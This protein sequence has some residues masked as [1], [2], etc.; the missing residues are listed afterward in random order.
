MTIL[1]LHVYLPF[2]FF[3]CHVYFLPA[4]SLLFTLFIYVPFHFPSYYNSLFIV[5][6]LCASKFA[7]S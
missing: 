2:L 5:V 3:I 7:R 4:L 6:L 1:L